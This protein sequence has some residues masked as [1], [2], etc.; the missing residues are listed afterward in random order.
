MPKTGEMSAC[1]RR[2]ELKTRV[3]KKNQGQIREVRTNMRYRF[4]PSVAEGMRQNQGNR[5][6]IH[7]EAK[8]AGVRRALKEDGR[9]MSACCPRFHRIGYGYGYRKCNIGFKNRWVKWDLDRAYRIFKE[10]EVQNVLKVERTGEGLRWV[11]SNFKPV[12][13]SNPRLSFR[14]KV[15]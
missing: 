9:P 3:G 15:Q 7:S 14:K 11:V 5:P 12:V 6:L 8:R 1:A 2:G 13:I 4:E 10:Q